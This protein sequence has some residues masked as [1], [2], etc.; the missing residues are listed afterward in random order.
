MATAKK[1]TA[2]DAIEAEAAPEV[3]TPV[4]DDDVLDRELERIIADES[5]P[6]KLS[7]GTYVIVRPLKLKEL[8]AAFKIIAA[9]S[10]AASGRAKLPKRLAIPRVVFGSS[11]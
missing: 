5:A 8:F 3:T 10:L 11:R 2:E 4:V 7:D 9:I 6:L 1:T